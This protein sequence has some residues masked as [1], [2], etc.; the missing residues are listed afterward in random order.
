MSSL[1][2]GAAVTALTPEARLLLACARAEADAAQRA[3]IRA[4]LRAEI[5]WTQ[6]I[7]LA[8]QHRLLPLLSHQLQTL[9]ADAVP[10]PVL[11]QLR[12]QAALS[13]RHSLFLTGE[14]LKLLDRFSAH[15]IEAITLKGPVLATVAYGNL[16]LRQFDDL[17]VLVR[18]RDMLRARDLLIAQGFEP[19]VQLT[20]RQT[21]SYLRSQYVYPL[22]SADGSTIVELHHDIRPRYFAFH[23][24]PDRLWRR[25]EPLTL[26][27]RAVLNLAP[28]DL[29]L[30]LCVHG[31]NHCWE[32]VAWICDV[33]ELLRARPGLDWN[34]VLREARSSGAQRMLLLGLLLARDLLG[35]V[36]PDQV[37]GW[38]AA[39]AALP[40]L[41]RDVTAWLFR[42][43]APPLTVSTRAGFH[44]RVR[45]RLRDRV[46]YC[47]YLL[48]SPTEEDWTVQPLPA[49][50]SFLYA[51]CRPLKLLG[52]YG[53]RPLKDLIGR[54]DY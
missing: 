14:L 23:V 31:A 21:A 49:A 12:Q 2:T 29:L 32:R 36:L 1:S 44:L 51:L 15:S 3:T 27:G 45:E 18:T 19:L 13:A 48:T 22:V 37:A 47:V 20:E 30:L 8:Q 43:A 5:R 10:Q 52:R 9:G 11:D 26:G 34:R 46:Q 53:M 7:A 6:V 54:Q 33:A 42:D 35:A 16:A 25:L 4:L 40:S 41:A 50:L 24:D 39:D 38:I 28:E 17:D